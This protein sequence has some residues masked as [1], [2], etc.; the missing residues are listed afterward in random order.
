[1][2]MLPDGS[3]FT[4]GNPSPTS[5]LRYLSRMRENL[6][7]IVL[8]GSLLGT[9]RLDAQSGIER[10]IP[11]SPAPAGFISDG[12]PV[13]S[14]TELADLND[15][16]EAHQ[17]GG[18]GDIGVAILRDIGDYTAN[19]VGLSI[20][21]SWKIG[22]VDSLG[23]D[24]R[25][26][27]VLLLIVPKELSP[28]GMGDCYITTGLGAEG[29]ITDATAGRICREVIVPFLVKR[30]YAGAIRAG[31]DA[32]AVELTGVSAVE[33][34]GV[35]AVQGDGGSSG[36]GG[37]LPGGL[38][39][40]LAVAGG[41]TGGVVAYRKRKRNKPRLCPN[42]HGEMKRLDEKADDAAL[43]RGQLREEELKSVDYDVWQ[44]E[45]CG[46]RLVVRYKRWF[47]SY[48]QCPQCKF[49]T[50]KSKTRTLI[51]ATTS[52]G[53]LAETTR[54]CHNCGFGDTQQHATPRL[55][56]S[57]SSSGGSSSGGGRSFGGSGR[58]AGGGGGSRY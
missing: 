28:S 40:L 57:S 37:G 19:E 13:L 7:A 3:L 54:T 1:M 44:C 11:P 5:G 41:G 14:A 32:I 56:S 10:Y 4:S 29:F 48:T 9:A 8:A 23:S 45:T 38:I 26:L 47:T 17:A 20:Y 24:R 6:I 52:S 25:D 53:G 49:F 43:E 36:E 33:G 16:I 31:I 50:V 39:A 21:R 58:S 35:R 27:G 15:R 18:R 42:G 51:P 12:G 2:E 34:T 55:S 22:S 30:D 46:E